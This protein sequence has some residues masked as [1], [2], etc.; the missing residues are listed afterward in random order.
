MDYKL[1]LKSSILFP[2]FL[3]VVIGITLFILGAMDDSPGLSAIGLILG[4]GLI[5]IGV[6]N[7]GKINENIKTGVIL[8]LFYGI[9]GFIGFVVL[10]FDNEFREFPQLFFIG[11]TVCMVLIVIGMIILEKQY[12]N[13][14]VSFTKYPLARNARLIFNTI[15]L[16]GVI[17][18]LSLLIVVFFGSDELPNPDAMVSMKFSAFIWLILG[19]LPMILSG[20]TVYFF[21]NLKNSKHKIRNT[22]LIFIPGFICLGFFLFMMFAGI[23][24]DLYTKYFK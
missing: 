4:T 23:I 3:G 10:Y 14:R 13:D 1:Y 15:Y 16:T 20:I 21:N 24:I 8:P 18:V 17:C 5:F 12:N 2:G 7:M 6:H 9:T 22:I 19:T 11:I